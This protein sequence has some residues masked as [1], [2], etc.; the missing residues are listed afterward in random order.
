MNMQGTL[1]LVCGP[2]G[3]GKGTLLSCVR[4]RHPECVYPVSATTR[5][6]RS[7]ETDGETYHFLSSETFQQRIEA[8]AFLE[9][10]EYGGNRYGTPKDEVLAPLSAGAVVVHEIE[11]QG[12]RTLMEILPRDHIVLVFID[13]GSWETLRARI[14]ER[15]PMDD[16]QLARRR[17]RYSDEMTLRAQADHV[18]DNRD[19][20]AAAACDA[21][22]RIVADIV[23]AA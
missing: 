11:A 13:A 7:G 5:P 20:N 8:D 14:E 1:I 17:A 19:G 21:L 16:T 3:S 6:P 23:S 10:A 15:G 2:S 18:I 12:V 4:A 9:W 22:D